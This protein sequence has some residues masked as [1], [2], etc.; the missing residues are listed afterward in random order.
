MTA[1]ILGLMAAIWRFGDTG[2]KRFLYLAA[3][4][5]GTALATKFGAIPFV[6]LALPF[7][8]WEVASHRKPPGPKPAVVGALA[9][10]LLLAVALPP[11]VI[12]YSKTG[13]PLFPFLRSEEHTSELQSLR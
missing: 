2:E 10:V 1:M 6:A 12:A 8:V 7:A 5:G 4:L 3:V 13:N 11:Y 9:A